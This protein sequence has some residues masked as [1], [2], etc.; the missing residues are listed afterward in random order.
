ML[1]ILSYPIVFIFFWK[2]QAVTA[3]SPGPI[4]IKCICIGDDVLPPFE[5][6]QLSLQLEICCCSR[7]TVSYNTASAELHWTKSNADIARDDSFGKRFT[8]WTAEPKGGS[9]AQKNGTTCVICNGLGADPRTVSAPWFGC[10][11]SSRRMFLC[12]F[13]L[14]VSEAFKA[15]YLK[16]LLCLWFVDQRNPRLGFFFLKSPWV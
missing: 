2:M 1:K 7:E 13:T 16:P 14:E 5:A 6:I 4:F 12:S 3:L 8:A 15:K 9:E 10:K 11:P